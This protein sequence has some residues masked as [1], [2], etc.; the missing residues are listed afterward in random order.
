MGDNSIF[1]Y[2]LG[3]NHDV[4]EIANVDFSAP[5]GTRTMAGD[6]SHE[7]HSFI[8]SANLGDDPAHANQV[9]DKWIQKCEAAGCVPDVLSLPGV[10]SVMNDCYPPSKRRASE[11][12]FIKQL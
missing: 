5:E 1:T 6:L 7:F 4:V 12:G 11:Y 10:M 3:P 9:M 2:E 8:E